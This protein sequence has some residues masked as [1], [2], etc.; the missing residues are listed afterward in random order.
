[1]SSFKSLDAVITGYA[2]EN[3]TTALGVLEEGTKTKKWIS[4]EML[5]T[6]DNFIKVMLF[7]D[8]IFFGGCAGEKEG[9]VVPR[10][11]EFGA[12]EK[13]RSLF[14]DDGI[15][16]PINKFEGDGELARRIVADALKPVDVSSAALFVLTG[17]WETKQLVIRQE[18]VTIDAFFIEHSIQHG[19]LPMFKPVFPGEHLYLG[20]RQSVIKSPIATHTI[21][22]LVGR[23]IRMLVREK[24]QNLN[25]TL[26]PI[27]AAPI[28]TLPPVF[29]ARTLYDCSTPSFLS[30]ILK[31]Q[32]SGEDIVPTLLAI[33][34][35]Q[36]MTRIRKWMSE[37]MELITSQD[38]NKLAQ[39]KTI[40]DKLNSFPL[41][42]D[43][44]EEEFAKGSLDIIADAA[45]GD[46]LGILAVL[47]RPLMK[48]YGGFPMGVL[49]GL[50]GQ[51][52]ESKH[53]DEFLEKTFTAKFTP[54]EMDYVSTLL[55]LPD[56]VADWKIE[57]A[58]FQV[59]AGRIDSSAPNLSRPCFV[60]SANA[61]YIENA[62]TDFDD[63]FKSAVPLQDKNI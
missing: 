60:R 23:R 42:D 21:A 14:D 59:T 19:G 34:N 9:Y 8:R 36:A 57:K 3:A 51:K 38:V 39:A 11:A 26:V 45:K 32:S 18:M 48:Y 53:I 22:D 20:L 41:E 16:H 4:T 12:S 44:T 6:L 13:A 28:P 63:L 50:G 54:S 52:G 33:R 46:V 58:L 5:C 37:C 25:N 61:H 56:N 35:S 27:G 7:S 1:M 62:K 49:R 29:V 24:M 15:F 17:S 2:Y 43:I 10:N 47:V 55:E 30:R 40:Y 31:H